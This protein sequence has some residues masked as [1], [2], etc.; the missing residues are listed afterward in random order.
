MRY[1][2]LN[3]KEHF[4]DSRRLIYVHLYNVWLLTTAGICL[5]S[6]LDEV[7]VIIFHGVFDFRGC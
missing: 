5:V 7:L 1:R 4:F 3:G 6:G 2:Y